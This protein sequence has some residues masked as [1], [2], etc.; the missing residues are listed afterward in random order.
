MQTLRKSLA[1]VAAL[2]L[3]GASF[4]AS[5]VK[6][7]VAACAQGAV[8]AVQLGFGAACF[9]PATVAQLLGADKL[10]ARLER[11]GYVAHYRVASFLAQCRNLLGAWLFAGMV[12]GGLILRAFPGTVTADVAFGVV[13]ELAFDGPYR[14]QP[15]RIN[16]GTAA[17]IVVGRWF[18]LNAAGEALPGGTGAIGGVLMAP[19]T[20]ASLGTAAGGALAPT[21]VLPTGTIG[22][23]A[24]M[25]AIVV[26]VGAAVAIGNAAKYNTTTGVIGV[27]APG[28]GEAAIPNAKFI[29]YANAAAGLAVLELTN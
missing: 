17:D 21:M 2:A 5:T 18:T 24:Y 12:R 22:E 26:A 6:E 9:A 27:G 19:K 15:A 20:H 3:A 4:L 7:A 10:A 28:A 8:L 29:R 23:F 16:H 13:G 11:A 14:S 1:A 25:G